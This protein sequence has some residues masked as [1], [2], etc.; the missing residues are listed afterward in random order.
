MTVT[1][2][3]E[4]TKVDSLLT[5]HSVST[6]FNNKAAARVT[7][8]TE[9]PYTIRK[10]TQIA[11]FSVEAPEQFNFIEPLYTAILKMILED[12]PVLITYLIGLLTANNPEQQN[13]LF[14]SPKSET[15]GKSEDHTPKQTQILKEL[16]ELKKKEE[17]N[18]TDSA[19]SR[20]NS[21]NDLI[22]LVHCSR[23]L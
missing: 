10:N 12:N 13:N 7:S 4:I 22:G 14:W 20:K 8:T 1:L 23:M 19:E 6:I 3:E 18:P 2:L 5:S 17:L 16:N 15:V 21:F 9:S 11:E